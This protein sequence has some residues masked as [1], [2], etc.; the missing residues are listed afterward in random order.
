MLNTK[1]SRR[2]RENILRSILAKSTEISSRETVGVSQNC[3]D[4]FFELIT[5]KIYTSIKLNKLFSSWKRK[6]LIPFINFST[7]R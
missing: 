5:L 1:L 7:V 2:V 4:P 3:S 6:K